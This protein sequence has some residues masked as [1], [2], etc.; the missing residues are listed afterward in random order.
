MEYDANDMTLDNQKSGWYEKGQKARFVD[1]S[2][3]QYKACQ[4]E[5]VFKKS[6]K[7]MKSAAQRYEEAIDKDIMWKLE[8]EIDVEPKGPQL[9]EEEKSTK[10][11]ILRQKIS[12]TDQDFLDKEHLMFTQKR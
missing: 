10:Q 8:N 2:Q 11:V 4:L 6:F 7:K 9:I 5:D 3:H 12:G 1:T